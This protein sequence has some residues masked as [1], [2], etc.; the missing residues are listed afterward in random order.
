V[1]VTLQGETS[2]VGSGFTVDP[3]TNRFSKL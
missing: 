1:H 3:A 2:V